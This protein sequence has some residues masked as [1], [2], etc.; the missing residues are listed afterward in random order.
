MA[1]GISSHRD[2]EAGAI[3]QPRDR[4]G[5]IGIP[6]RVRRVGDI[7]ARHIAAQGD[8]VMNA[9]PPP[10]VGD[11]IDLFTARADT[12]QMGCHRHVGFIVDAA[13]HPGGALARGT[14]G[15]VS[16]RDEGRAKRREPRHNMPQAGL[17]GIVVRRKEFET[18]QGGVVHVH[19]FF[20]ALNLIAAD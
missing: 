18:D 15:A 8:D 11:R 17:A 1:F 7:G 5:R 10:A 4:I 13:D 19:S 9:G 16:D 14:A 2:F 20:Y 3:A 6:F 12:G